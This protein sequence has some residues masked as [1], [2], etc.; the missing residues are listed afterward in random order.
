MDWETPLKIIH[1]TKNEIFYL[2]EPELEIIERLQSRFEITELTAKIIAN[3]GVTTEA[4]ATYFLNP[5]LKNLPD[6]FLFQDM[7]KAVERLYSAITRKESILVYG[8]YDV[9]GITSTTLFLTFFESIALPIRFHIPDRFSDG[10]GLNEDRLLALY[11][12][13][14]FHLLITVD[15]GITG[16]T[17]ITRLKEMGV[18]TI[19]TDHHRA[20]TRPENAV[21][22]LN[23]SVKGCSFPFKD[24]A[25]V[26]VV[27]FLLIALRAFLREKGFW[28]SERLTEP[29]LRKFLDIVCIGT[30]ADMVPLL[31]VNRTLVS[32]GLKILTHSENLGLKSF[33]ESLKLSRDAISPWEISFQIA[34]RFNATGRMENGST[35]VSLLMAK[36]GNMARLISTKMESLN[37]KRHSIEELM[38]EDM[39][40]KIEAN[41]GYMTPFAIVLWSSEWHEGIIG[42]VA[43]KLVDIYARPVALISLR[44]S[45]GKGSIRGIPGIDIFKV[46]QDCK[47]WLISYG[48]HSMAGGIKIEESSLTQ[49]AK[50][51]SK[52]I[53]KQNGGRLPKKEWFMDEIISST[54]IFDRFFSELPKLEPFGLGNPPPLFGFFDFEVL[55]KRLI[56]DKHIRF[57]I[58]PQ[59]GKPIQA[60]AFNAAEHWNRFESASGI[61]GV[62]TIN[63]WKGNV[64]PQINVR[65][66]LYFN[67]DSI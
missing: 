27:F 56:R 21:A 46:L 26:G 3:R 39:R 42:I 31:G 17:A 15:C 66:F 49:F 1:E 61:V 11:S 8:D 32:Y 23:P 43:S 50:E 37:R 53:E 47:P 33:L 44:E 38:L 18:D 7:K 22:V 2:R 52:S 58:R 35:G 67:D 29:D 60:I 20:E 30:I 10:Y 45:Y 57:V 48:G 5:L 34:P 14:P 13:S 40:E 65:K 25:G 55:S 64:T 59:T 51:F 4:E 19:V 12:E 41:A 63:Y 9:D 24:L 28:E 36:D 6:P 54:D 16:D 62:P